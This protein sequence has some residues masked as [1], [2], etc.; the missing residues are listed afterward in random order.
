[1]VIFKLW[2]IGES[3]TVKREKVL[4]SVV[5]IFLK[6]GRYVKLEVHGALLSVGCY[7]CSCSGVFTFLDLSSSM[8]TAYFVAI[9]AFPTLRQHFVRDNILS[10]R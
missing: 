2:V 9:L 7:F 10:R 8:S 5:T 4:I 3:Q 6:Q 1:M